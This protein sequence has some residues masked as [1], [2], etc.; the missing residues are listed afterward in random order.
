MLIFFQTNSFVDVSTVGV[1]GIPEEYTSVQL[2][3]A[4]VN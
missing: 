4:N 2:L 1:E 3:V